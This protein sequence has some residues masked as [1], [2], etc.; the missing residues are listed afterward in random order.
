MSEQPISVDKGKCIN[1]TLC[2]NTCAF[3]SLVMEEG[4]PRI[5][6]DCRLCGECVTACPTKAITIEK[7]GVSVNFSDHSGILVFAEQWKGKVHPVVYELFG[8]GRELANQLEEKLSA[9]II[10]NELD[11][12]LSELKL[13]G[14][15]KIFVFDHPGLEDFRDDPY[16]AILENLVKEE[17]PSIFLIGATSIGRSLGPKVAACLETGLTADCT[18]LDIDPES[19]LLLQT[20]PTYGGNIMATIICTN[21]RPQIATVRY[22]VMEEA[23]IVPANECE[24]IRRNV[25]ISDLPDR[26]K[27]LKSNPV[28]DQVSIID[29][30]IIVSGGKGLGDQ[31]GFEL[32]QEL[33]EALG[34]AVGASRPTVD[35][36]WID[37]PHQVGLSGRTVRP[38]IY[39]ACGISGAVQHL[40]GM[41][42]SDV[43]IAINKDPEA[44]IFNVA[45]LGAVGDLYE[46]IPRLVNMIKERKKNG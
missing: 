46:V 37:Y 33:A 5:L 30:E 43:I 21:T 9:V 1:C 8:K 42:T 3:G 12:A 31:R 10:G 22:K 15:D 45:S 18:S 26:V 20:R 39:V 17:K 29:A 27:I 14:A 32:I 13:R 34:G 7:E 6:D 24:I 2:E 25:T 44:P 4:Y 38:R 11:E 41:K 35:E 16:S 40:A 19:R 23:E 28:K 36:G